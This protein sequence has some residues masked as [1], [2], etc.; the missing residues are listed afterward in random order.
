MFWYQLIALI[1]S[2]SDQA[3]KVADRLLLF[4]SK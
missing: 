4:L 3:E 2:I 1:G